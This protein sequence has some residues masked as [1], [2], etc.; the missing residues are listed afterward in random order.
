MSQYPVVAGRRATLVD[1]VV[2]GSDRPVEPPHEGNPLT[3]E[4]NDREVLDIDEA[5]KA[6]GDPA[7]FPELDAAERRIRVRLLRDGFLACVRVG[8]SLGFELLPPAVAALTVRVTDQRSNFWFWAKQCPVRTWE[9]HGRPAIGVWRGREW[10]S[11]DDDTRLGQ[12]VAIREAPGQGVLL[13]F[14]DG[15]RCE[16]GADALFRVQPLSQGVSLPTARALLDAVAADLPQELA[17]RLA[18]VRAELAAA[19]GGEVGEVAQLP[20]GQSWLGPGGA[21][22]T[23]AVP[24]S[25]L[26]DGAVLRPQVPADGFGADLAPILG[27]LARMRQIP[28]GTPEGDLARRLA[29]LLR[30][31]ADDVEQLVGEAQ[32]RRGLDADRRRAV[33]HAQTRATMAYAQLVRA[34]RLRP[35]AREQAAR[36]LWRADAGGDSAWPVAGDLRAPF[37]AQ[38]DELLAEVVTG[39]DPASA[40]CWADSCPLAD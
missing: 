34:A 5:V 6:V 38:A 16:T 23:R 33:V 31:V 4:V 10:P 14:E 1:L 30:Q 32:V 18:A 8:G 19:D 11:D 7:Q 35:D 3:V 21:E 17:A 26:P 39:Q 2:A 29:V 36:W 28:D 40:G 25:Q 24:V 15:A 27:R 20:G 22:L 37:Y 12:L 13:T 9:E